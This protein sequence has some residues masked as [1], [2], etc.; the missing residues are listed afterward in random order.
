MTK[1]PTT[2]RQSPKSSR[3]DSGK[4]GPGPSLVADELRALI[5]DGS[6]K[7]GARITERAVAER[8]HCTAATTREAF[9]LLEKQ[10]AIIVSARRGA[11]VIDDQYAPPAE[12]FIV[13]DRLRWLLGEELRRHDASVEQLRA[14]EITAKAPSRRLVLVE[15]QLE[16]LGAASRNAR[17]ARAMARIALHV[18]IV[19]PERL[20]EIGESLN[21]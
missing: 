2:T 12:L 4:S 21:R 7:A 11:R 9:H 17:L 10:G 18:S 20:G 13:W 14:G 19:A 6:F 15:E 5:V 1:K 16:R 3:T 8:F